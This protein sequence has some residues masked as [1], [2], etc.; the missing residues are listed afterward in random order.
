MVIATAVRLATRMADLGT[1]SAFEVLARARQLEREGHHIIH[2]EIGEPD[3]PTPQHVKDAANDALAADETKYG[4][5]AGIMPCREAV[6]EH[7]SETHGMPIS[8]EQVVITP[9]AKP[10]IFYAT[11]ALVDEGDEVLLPDPGFPIYESVVAFVG[12]TPFPCRSARPTSSGSRSQS[13]SGASP[14]GRR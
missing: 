14:R 8:P 1:E 9:G 10:P 13:W 6:A 7:V 2:M 12:G 4:P 5:S 11:L 3:F